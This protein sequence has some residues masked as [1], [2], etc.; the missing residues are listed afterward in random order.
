MQAI[1]GLQERSEMQGN[2]TRYVDVARLARINGRMGGVGFFAVLMVLF[3]VILAPAMA[4]TG[5]QGAIEGTVTD[6]TGAVVYNA[7]V[8][9]TNQASGVTTSRPTSSSGL[10][11]I[12][13]VIPG[14]LPRDGHGERVPEGNAT[15]PG[16]GRA[17]GDRPEPDIDARGCATESVTVT[18]APPELQTTNATLGGV[19]ENDTYRESAVADERTA[20]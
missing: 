15:E 10:Y 6:A 3:G 20:A 4:Q 18:E 11:T 8:T 13:P 2:G 5:G 12:N 19:I 1:E 9:A 14:T 16:C 17:E 7:T